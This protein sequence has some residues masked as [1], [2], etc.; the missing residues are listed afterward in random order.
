MTSIV[1]EL[2]T[3]ELLLAHHITL[4][5]HSLLRS[6]CHYDSCIGNLLA[7]YSPVFV[8]DTIDDHLIGI[9]GIHSLTL[10]N[11]DYGVSVFYISYD[12]SFPCLS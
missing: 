4:H 11:A 7:D 5:Y 1:L 6:C 12:Y 9:A 8:Y 2:V 10:N 3:S